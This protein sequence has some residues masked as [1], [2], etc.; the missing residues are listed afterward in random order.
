MAL[1]LRQVQL[2]CCDYLLTCLE[3][4]QTLFSLCVRCS[5][6][7]TH[8]KTLTIASKCS[9]QVGCTWLVC[10]NDS[11]LTSCLI[12]E[13]AHSIVPS[14]EGLLLCPSQFDDGA[15]HRFLLDE[16]MAWG[17]FQWQVLDMPTADLGAPA[18]RKIDF[19]V[20]C[21]I[22]GPFPLCIR[23]HRRLSHQNDVMFEDF[24]SF[25]QITAPFQERH[26]R[27]EGQCC[28]PHWVYALP[29]P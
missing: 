1:N 29:F 5:D 25:D 4:Y 9:Y 20:R 18:Y 17:C 3:Q 14:C 24:C 27:D 6:W 21:H 8:Q 11:T 16:A 22:S 12:I 7:F 28:E 10:P 13:P 2:N 26:R 23:V 19:E 15:T